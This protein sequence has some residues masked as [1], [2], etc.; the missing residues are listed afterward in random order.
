MN[1]Q[2]MNARNIFHDA[3]VGMSN[4]TRMKMKH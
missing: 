1:L 2:N 3:T 4:P